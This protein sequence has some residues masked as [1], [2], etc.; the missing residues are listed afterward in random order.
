MYAVCMY[1]GIMVRP[2][3][4]TSLPSV[5]LFL[6]MLCVVLGFVSFDPGG[7][8]GR[9][10]KT[11]DRTKDATE[12]RWKPRDVFTMVLTVLCLF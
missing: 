6:Y 10:F 4:Y 12:E 5:A 1:V 9:A 3:I 8:E 2:N 11:N 7:E